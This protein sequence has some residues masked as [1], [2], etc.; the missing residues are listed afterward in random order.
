PL[1]GLPAELRDEPAHV[2]D[3]HA[4]GR[5]G[6]AD[7]VLLEHDAAEVVRAVREGDLA[8]LLSLRHP[9][10]LDARDVVQVDAGERLHAKVFM[11]PGRRRLQDRVVWLEG[12]ADEGGEGAARE[13][14]LLERVR[15]G[16]GAADG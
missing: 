10:A 3:G 12:P 8:D 2:R 4:V 6:G 5:S 9:R 14:A 16:G 11:G 1:A 15:V 13:G 7:D